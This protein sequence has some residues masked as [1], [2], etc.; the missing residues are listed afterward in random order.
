MKRLLEV[1]QYGQ[2]RK[3]EIVPG[4][5]PVNR[6]LLIKLYENGND[7]GRLT[8]DLPK[9]TPGRNRAYIN[10]NHMGA[11]IIERLEEGGFGERTNMVRRSGFVLFPEFQFH[12]EVLREFMNEDYEQYLAW[13]DA[14][15]EDEQ[16]LSV[17][18]RECKEQF[19]FIVKRSEAQR[20]L[21]YKEGAK[22]LIQNVFP[23]MTPEER[24]LFAQ[25][26]NICGKCL[27]ELFP[28]SPNEK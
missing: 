22:Y 20:Y 1:E 17:V 25:G 7:F 28:P 15:K 14:L 19:H 10:V 8:C 24:G 21:E 5:Y 12:E 16:Y 26:Q 18:C 4:Y 3:L 23:N 11:D 13:Q 6:I 2:I 27:N 9:A